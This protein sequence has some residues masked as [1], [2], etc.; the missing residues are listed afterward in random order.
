VEV[1]MKIGTKR[2][3]ESLSDMFWEAGALFGMLLSTAALVILFTIVHA[4]HT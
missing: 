4:I 2:W 1:V 3:N